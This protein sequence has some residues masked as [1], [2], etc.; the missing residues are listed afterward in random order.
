MRGTYLGIGGTCVEEV[1]AL[2]R[3]RKIITTTN[4]TSE[5]DKAIVESL[6]GDCAVF[7]LTW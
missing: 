5:R 2:R 6:S 7:A 1:G 3:D 4:T